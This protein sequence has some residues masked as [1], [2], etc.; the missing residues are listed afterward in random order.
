MQTPHF[1]TT[2]FALRDS[3][4]AATTSIRRLRDDAANLFRQ[5]RAKRLAG[6]EEEAS[7]LRDEGF[8]ARQSADCLRWAA[9][10]HHLAFAFLRG[11]PYAALEGT[12]KR[13]PAPPAL[14]IVEL[15]G[16]LGCTTTTAEVEAWVEGQE[17]APSAPSSAPRAPIAAAAE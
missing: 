9:R 10:S 12:R 5:A 8:L 3:T 11:R 4:R 17:V 2:F 6:L 7:A 13:A 16:V 14:A 15:L 1:L